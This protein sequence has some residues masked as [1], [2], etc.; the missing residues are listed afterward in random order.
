M[1]VGDGEVT[2][3]GVWTWDN[4]VEFHL[5]VVHCSAFIQEVLDGTCGLF[6]QFV[7]FLGFWEFVVGPL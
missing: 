2:G 1:F 5:V 4:S 3:A 6:C 7:Y